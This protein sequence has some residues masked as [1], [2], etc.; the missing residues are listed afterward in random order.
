MRDLQ[1]LQRNALLSVTL[2]KANIN[3]TADLMLF[4]PNLRPE[5]QSKKVITLNF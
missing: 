5:D 2:H 1:N 3:L 4:L